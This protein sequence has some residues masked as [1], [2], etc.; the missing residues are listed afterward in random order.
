M[1]SKT[2]VLVHGAWVTPASWIEFKTLYEA[3]GYTVVVPAWPYMDKPV[4]DLRRQP[5][6]RV[7]Q[8]TIR[9]LVDHFEAQIRALPERPILMG[10][11]FGGLIVQ[12]LLDR[13]LGVAGVA[14]DP[15]PPRGVLPTMTAIMSALPVLLAFRGWN[16][17]LT[18][19]FKSFSRTFANTVPQEQQRAVF[20]QHIVPAPGRI[21]FQAALGIGN[22]IDFKNPRRPPLLLIAA[23]QDRTS[24]PSMVHAM[25]RKHSRSP[26]RTEIMMFPGRSHWLIAEAGAEEVAQ[27][28]LAWATALSTSRLNP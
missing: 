22:G 8:L 9:N 7:A 16:R 10:H 20:E 2:I 14:I 3:A 28:A 27:R 17:I 26:A 12:M 5:D 21:Y 15:G 19:S 24:P 18:M 6:P 11:S 23:E 13:G 1:M 25:Y 4:E